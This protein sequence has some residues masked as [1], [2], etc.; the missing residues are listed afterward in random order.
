M[1]TLEQQIAD[2]RLADKSLRQTALELGTTVHKVRTVEKSETFAQRLAAHRQKVAAVSYTNATVISEFIARWLTEL[3][4]DAILD[5]KSIRD[6]AWIASA[7][8]RQAEALLGRTTQ[9]ADLS[10]DKELEEATKLLMARV[11]KDK[12][13]Q[14]GE[15]IDVPSSNVDEAEVIPCADPADDSADERETNP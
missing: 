10:G 11:L 15:V 12:A 6:L 14:M 4:A 9:D 5:T 8:F 3:P 1:R 7:Q 2:A 13:K